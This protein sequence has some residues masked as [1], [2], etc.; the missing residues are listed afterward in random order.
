MLSRHVQQT[1]E[2]NNLLEPC[3]GKLART[4]LRGEGLREEPDLPDRLADAR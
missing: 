1:C 3:A 4:V 2:A